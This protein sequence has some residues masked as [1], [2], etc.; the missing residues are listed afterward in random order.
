MM[1]LR[2]IS[3]IFLY[4]PLAFFSQEVRGD[5]EKYLEEDRK[6]ISVVAATRYIDNSFGLYAD[7]Q[8]F[9]LKPNEAFY[10]EFLVRYRWLDFNISFEPKLFKINNDDDVKGK[11][12]YFDIGFAFFLCPKI[13]QVINYTHIKGFYL[14]STQKF[15]KAFLEPEL[16]DVFND[17]YLQF[18]D[19]KYQSFR[20]ETSYLWVGDKTN[21]RSYTNMTYKPLKNN[22][23]LISGLFYQ[24][25]V[26]RDANK[27]IYKGREVSDP[28]FHTTVTK[29]IRVALRSGAGMQKVL[30]NNWYTVMELYPQVYYA[31]L[32]DSKN[33]EFN[34]GLNS[35]MR[36]GYDNGKWFFGGE[37][38]INWLNS[39]KVNFYSTTQ[40]QV[41]VGV[42]VRIGSPKFV[43][44]T[45][46]KIENIL[47]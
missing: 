33:Y 13:R 9:F 4:F 11:T 42:G 15:V 47:E 18:P 10:T 38:Q 2:L 1:K 23:V 28:D 12:R 20:G 45:F 21:Y 25:N 43:N 16:Q 5:N 19:S 29:D 17:G 40:W 32:I 8:T 22:F 39:S 31:T 7:R 6:K 24:Y 36:I 46:D 30:K 34:V 41:R 14:E 44:K 3:S 26:L 35:N 27:M 37:G